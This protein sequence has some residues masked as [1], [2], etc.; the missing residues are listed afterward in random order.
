MNRS[1]MMT[2]GLLF[3]A[4]GTALAWQPQ[5]EKRPSSGQVQDADLMS[6][7]DFM[8]SKL[9]YSQL[10]L[11]GLTTEDFEMVNE[12]IGK[13]KEVTEGE[14]W[15]AFDDD[16]EYRDLTQDFRNATGRLEAAA[17]TENLDAV[18]MRFYQMST[19][20][21]DCHKHIRDRGYKL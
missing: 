12:A 6:R 2:L 9:M 21:I 10:I 3:L 18:A 20:C 7:R 5:E 4:G 19:T 13:L 15:V 1:L 17:A 16:K 14:M 11:E 8:R